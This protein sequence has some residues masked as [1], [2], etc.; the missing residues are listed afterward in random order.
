MVETKI[1]VTID[2]GEKNVTNGRN[3]KT[4]G[5]GHVRM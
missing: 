4:D 3:A 1:E 2:A 5:L